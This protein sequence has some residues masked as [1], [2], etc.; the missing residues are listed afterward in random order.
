[1]I[2]TDEMSRQKLQFGCCEGD[3]QL[4]WQ[5]FLPLISAQN[6]HFHDSQLSQY[7]CI[8]AEHLFHIHSGAFELKISEQSLN[9]DLEKSLSQKMQILRKEGVKQ[10]LLFKAMGSP[11]SKLKILDCTAGFGEDSLWFAAMGHY[12]HM[13]ERNP[14]LFCFLANALKRMR[15]FREQLSL[16]YL[17]SQNSEQIE[18]FDIV[19][20]DPFFQKKKSAK[21]KK[22]MQLMGD[23]FHD[24]DL[25]AEKVA[26]NLFDN[27]RTRLIIKRADKAPVLIKNPTYEIKGKTV[28]YDIYYRG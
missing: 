24:D 26:Q 8:D 28:R 22:N 25:D 19:Y 14:V 27:C 5:E 9:L 16:S 1:M 3:R 11:K 10:Q 2:N 4:S 21:T 23:L 13:Q 20:Y 15:S 12:S 18:N 17:D 6:I 7:F